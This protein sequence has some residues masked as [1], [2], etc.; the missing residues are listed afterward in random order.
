MVLNLLVLVPAC[1]I[2]FLWWETTNTWI[3]WVRWSFF[4]CGR[5][6]VYKSLRCQWVRSTR[7]MHANLLP[8]RVKHC[9]AN[10]QELY[11]FLLP[12]G[13]ATIPTPWRFWSVSS[14]ELKITDFFVSWLSTSSSD[15]LCVPW[16][17]LDC[18][19]RVECCQGNYTLKNPI[20]LRSSK[21][22][23]DELWMNLFHHKSYIFLKCWENW[24]I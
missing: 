9:E 16:A 22:Y 18:T 24:N 5:N 15:Y 11:S 14:V 7:G 10:K 8:I 23:K 17:S 2:R 13:V 20:S 12:A 4:H 1:W 21:T 6:P 3:T 19:L